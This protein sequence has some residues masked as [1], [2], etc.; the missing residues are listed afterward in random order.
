MAVTAFMTFTVSFTYFF[1]EAFAVIL[2]S[3]AAFTA[4]LM[5]LETFRAVLYIPGGLQGFS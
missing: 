3:V 4:F 1:V 5:S 2:M